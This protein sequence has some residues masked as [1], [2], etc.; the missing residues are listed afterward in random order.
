MFV[1]A[2]DA[3]PNRALLCLIVKRSKPVPCVA[4]S[5]ATTEQKVRPV[6]PK[7][8]YSAEGWQAR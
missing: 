8:A 7:S 4:M 3:I 6:S 5:E 1:S 2:W